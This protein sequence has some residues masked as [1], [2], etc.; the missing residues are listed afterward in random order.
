MEQRQGKEQAPNK[1]SFSSI[2]HTE[3]KHGSLISTLF[4]GAEDA[5]K[6]AELLMEAVEESQGIGA[7][8]TVTTITGK[9]YDSGYTYVNPKNPPQQREDS[10]PS[11][12]FVKKSN[13]YYG[14]K[15][16]Y[17]NNSGAGKSF[18]KFGAGK[19]KSY[20]NSKKLQTEEVN[21]DGAQE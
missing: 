17:G 19:T 3:N 21:E 4:L 10:Q 2:K 7:K 13:N 12:K 20:L 18:S 14:N 1:V 5:V 15:K 8:L 9:S 11:S 16:S 6:L